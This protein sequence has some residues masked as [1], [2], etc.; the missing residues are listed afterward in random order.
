MDLFVHK[1]VATQPLATPDGLLSSDA[2]TSVDQTVGGTPVLCPFR[3]FICEA[4][5]RA[6]DPF[7]S[8]GCHRPLPV[9]PGKRPTP[10]FHSSK[11]SAE[12]DP[13]PSLSFTHQICGQNFS[14]WAWV[15]SKPWSPRKTGCLSKQN[16]QSGSLLISWVS[17]VC[18]TYLRGECA[19]PNSQ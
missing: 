7:R 6:Q 17:L 13:Q 10:P 4:K 12:L 18:L 15:S 1:Q 2:F 14:S 11:Q 9:P 8:G 3:E 19:P 5:P 16:S